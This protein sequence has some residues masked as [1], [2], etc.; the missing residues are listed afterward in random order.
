[1][2]L[3]LC[4]GTLMRWHKLKAQRNRHK[5]M[6]KA[7]NPIV[8]DAHGKTTIWISGAYK[9]RV[10]D[11]DGNLIEET[12][13]VSAFSAAAVSSGNAYFESLSG[14]GVTTAFN[15]SQNLGTDE[16]SI[17]VFVSE[18]TSGFFQSFSG[19][20]TETEFTLSQD[21]GTD[22]KSLIVFIGGEP[23]NPSSYTVDGETLTFNTAPVNGTDN[24]F[25]AQ[26]NKEG[27][28][29]SGLVN[30]NEYTLN[31]DT[32]TFST[33]PV[34]GTNNI[35][36][37]APSTL[38]NAAS[39]SAESADTSA[40]NAQS[41]ATASA[42]SETN[43]ATSA[44]NAATSEAN[45]STHATNASNSADL[46]E[47]W[48]I[49]TSGTV[50]GSEYSAKHYAQQ[51]AAAVSGAVKITSNDAIAGD[52]N[53]KLLAGSNV[54]KTLQ[55]DGGN[56][57]MTLSVPSASGS[58]KG[59][60]QKATSGDMSA[61]TA[62]QFPDCAVVKNYVDTQVASNS[63]L[64]IGTEQA[65]TSGTS[66]TFTIPSGAK[67][68]TIMF[69]EMSTDTSTPPFLRIG[70][71]GGIEN[72]GYVSMATGVGSGT[73]S[74]SSTTQFILLSSGFSVSTNFLTGS[75]TLINMGGNKWVLSGAISNGIHGTGTVSGVKTLTEELTT[76][77]FAT[78]GNFDSGSVRYQKIKL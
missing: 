8:L 52:L 22:E 10:E 26:P 36:I 77:E 3:V 62:D 12:D 73:S 64:S 28:G 69:D 24:I 74:S 16:K 6:H 7:T 66:K 48:A 32:I 20:D 38:V 5:R 65:T 45:S 2:V 34:T 21:M 31:G 40:N 55:N 46:A 30:P 71:A 58:N 11:S 59:V 43:A 39:A 19:D 53:S 23:Q 4:R 72:T 67:R 76:I 75:L 37:S 78:T 47:D 29:A 54:I 51:A 1:M 41:S 44:T 49:K 61:G 14:D 33:A 60:V 13:N 15:L 9:F 68:V 56:E 18:S 70:D 35:F 27:K 25:I 50:D 17:M 63:G 57:T 42:T